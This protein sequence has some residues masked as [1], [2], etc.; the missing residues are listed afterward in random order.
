[1]FIQ[2]CGVMQDARIS[3]ERFLKAIVIGGLEGKEIAKVEKETPKWDFLINDANCRNM[4]NRIQ[5]ILENAT[6]E[7]LLIGWV[8]MELIPQLKKLKDK[9]GNH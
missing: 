1:M 5:S 7:V 8:G 9:G 3:C 2:I 4:K 6:G